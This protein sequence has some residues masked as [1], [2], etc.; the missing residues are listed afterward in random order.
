MGRYPNVVRIS[1]PATA[2]APRAFEIP[3]DQ[4]SP[5]SPTK[6]WIDQYRDRT[7]GCTPRL[8]WTPPP[9]ATSPWPRY[10]TGP[11]CICLHLRQLPTVGQTQPAS[12]M[13]TAL[14]P[15]PD[16][17]SAIGCERP[18]S[19]GEHPTRIRAR[20]RRA[21]RARRTGRTPWR[22][23]PSSRQQVRPLRSTG[24]ETASTHSTTELITARPARRGM[25]GSPSDTNSPAPTG[26]SLHRRQPHRLVRHPR[27]Y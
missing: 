19:L 20:S 4:Q 24:H 26:E 27:Y 2:S 18:V 8:L 6:S 17:G 11:G 7:N 16:S 5:R 25:P 15:T 1:S 9:E 21:I 22:L 3:A 23:R 13:R 10:S 12:S 14:E